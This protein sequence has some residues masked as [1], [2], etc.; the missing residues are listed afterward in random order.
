MDFRLDGATVSSILIGVAALFAYLVSQAS[1]KSREDRRRL[2]RLVKRDIAFTR[3][4][5][6]VQVWAAQHG[7]DDLPKFPPALVESED[8]GDP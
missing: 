6:N 8:D 3:W 4:G 5:H 2:R 1:A 7:H